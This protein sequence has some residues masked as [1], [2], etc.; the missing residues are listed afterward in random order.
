MKLKGNYYQDYK[1]QTKGVVTWKL[2]WI[3]KK[4]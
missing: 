1:I 2:K 3:E 4:L